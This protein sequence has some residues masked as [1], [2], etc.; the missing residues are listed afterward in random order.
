[1]DNPR[2]I[3]EKQHVPGLHL[4]YQ[5]VE[6]SDRGALESFVSHVNRKVTAVQLGL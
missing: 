6:G 2:P 5:W 3:G 4:V 1:M